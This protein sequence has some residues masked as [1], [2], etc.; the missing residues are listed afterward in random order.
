MAL[1]KIPLG[2]ILELYSQKCGIPKCETISGVNIF[3]RFMSSRN[4]GSDTSNYLI[5]PPGHF[6]FNLMHVGRDGKIPVAMNDTD[7]DVIVSSKYLVF[8][9][10][11]ESIMLKEYLYILMT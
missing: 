4:V 11:D 2:E 9:I 8:R 1:S 10:I 7:S 5:V 3:K 6:A